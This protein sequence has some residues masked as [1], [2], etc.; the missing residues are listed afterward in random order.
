M[1][2]FIIVILFL[3]HPSLYW[4]QTENLPVVPS[5]QIVQSVTGY[6]TLENKV[7]IVLKGN[8]KGLSFTAYQISETLKNDLKL[9]SEVSSKSQGR[10]SIILSIIAGKKFTEAPAAVNNQAYSLTINQTGILIESSTAR[11]VFYG[12][13]TLIQLLDRDSSNKLKCVKIIDWPDLKVRGISD[14]ISR[15]QVSTLDNFKRIIRNIARYK[16]NVYMPYIED[17]LQF[18]QYPEI[19]KGRGALSAKEVSEIVSYAKKYYVD[20]IPAFETLG[21]FEN[22]LVRKRFLKY[23]EYPGSTALNV[24]NDSTYI[25]LDNLLK[26]VFKLFPSKYINIGEDESYDVGLGASKGLVQKYGLAAVLAGHCKKVY[27]FCKQHGKKVIMY[28]DMLPRHPGMLQMLPKD[29]I[30]CD[31]QYYPHSVYP[32]TN[33]FKDNGFYYYVSPSVSHF[34]TPFPDNATTLANIQYLTDEGIANGTSGMILSNWGSLTFKELYYYDYA[35]AAQCSWNS[36]SSNPYIFTKD[37]LYDFFGINDYRLTDIYETLSNPLNLVHW[38]KFFSHPLLDLHK[39]VRTQTN[40]LVMQTEYMNLTLPQVVR[41]ISAVEPKIKRNKNQLDIIKFIVKLDKWYRSRLQT[42]FF[43]NHKE[44]LKEKEYR[45]HAI[46]MLGDDLNSLDKLKKNYDGIWLRYYVKP[47]LQFVNDDFNRAAAY[48][49]E[50]KDSLQSGDDT[51]YSPLIKSKWIYVINSS[52]KPAEKAEFEKTINLSRVPDKA[53][54]Q[55][56]GDT[57][58]RLYINGQYVNEV[59]AKISGSTIVEHQRV[60]LI[61]VRKYLKQG[62]N[63]FL[64][65]AR[66]YDTNGAAGVNIDS[67]FQ[68]DGR[69]LNVN[70]DDANKPDS[71]KGKAEGTKWGRVFSKEYPYPVVAPNFKTLRPSWIER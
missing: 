17:M 38:N 39:W 30:I 2:Y 42:E 6:L 33:M 10:S 15:G 43:L 11:G 55:L 4:C 46:R 70:T 31:W 28:G 62:K 35:W 44:R 61:D 45:D 67:Y 26:V 64:I 12:A 37:F 8:K 18:P 36:K 27:E 9:P 63:T 65:K 47:G 59:Y 66:N 5:P 56:M 29:I 34:K 71:W 41:E 7:Q 16:M 3:I 14:D 69:I 13:M 49:E 68:V 54:I 1:K 24:S 57:Y 22:I 32:T 40:D 19:G 53:Y 20:V 23:A 58:V 25:F 60:K 21:H 51:L 52:G 50:I 48:L